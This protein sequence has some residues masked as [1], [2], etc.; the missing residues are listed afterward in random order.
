MRKNSLKRIFAALALSAVATTS[1]A[2]IS[3]FAEGEAT[4]PT[5]A[6]ETTAEETTAEET[7][8]G[9]TTAEETTAADTTAEETTADTA[10]SEGPTSD[11]GFVY[12]DVAGN[13]ITLTADE[14]AGSSVKPGV[15]VDTVE[16]AAGAEVTLKVSVDTTAWN[17]TG[18]HVNYDS[19]NLELVSASYHLDVLTSITTKKPTLYDGG[20]F[21]TTAGDI[22]AGTNNYAELTFKVT[23]AA[24]P[25]DFYPVSIDYVPGDIFTSSTTDE[26]TKVLMTAYTFT[27][28]IVNGGV[29]I[30]GEETAAPTTVAPT[31]APTTAAPTTKAPT[32]APV[33]T[34]SPKTGVAGVGVAAAGLVVA[35]GAAFVLRKKE[36]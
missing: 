13:Y 30:P 10:A 22:D 21:F 6:E 19:A 17:S 18:I 33:K 34:E 11:G 27:K 35:A 23:D 12:K 32:K 29:Q 7:T 3:A 1:V 5:T 24:K 16:G 28:G 20:A 4:E 14:I 25:G 9:D 36:D 15:T 8:A 26:D 2:S 31:A